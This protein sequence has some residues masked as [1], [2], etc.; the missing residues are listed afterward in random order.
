MTV[1]CKKLRKLELL[2]ELRSLE[3]EPE[4]ITRGKEWVAGHYDYKPRR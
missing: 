4:T 2:E 3:T 1:G